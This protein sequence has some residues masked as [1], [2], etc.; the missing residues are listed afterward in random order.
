[1]IKS[2]VID[3]FKNNFPMMIVFVLTIS[4]IR[5]VY[6]FTNRSRFKLY[7]EIINLTFIIYLLSLFYIVTFQDVNYGINNYAIFKEIF[8]YD[9][10]SRMFVKNVLGNLLLFIPLGYFISYYLKSKNFFFPIIISI[11]SSTSIEITQKYIG[12]VFDIDDILLNVFGALIGYLLY[13]SSKH[14]PRFT[15]KTWFLN[16]ISIILILGLVIWLLNMYNII[17]F[18]WWW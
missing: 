5:I 4:C 16:T 15:K 3:M 2:T 12:R 17:H 18:K 10:G 7:Q 9:I 1:M 11:I 8:R 13:K 6:L 14:L